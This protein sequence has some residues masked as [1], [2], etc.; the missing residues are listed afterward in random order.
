MLLWDKC[1]YEINN[2]PQSTNGHDF[3]KVKYDSEK[4]ASE[5]MQTIWKNLR[6]RDKLH[7]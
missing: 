2:A 3:G 4:S 7:F 5:T 6:G 1:C